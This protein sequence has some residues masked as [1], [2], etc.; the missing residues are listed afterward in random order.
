MI[1]IWKLVIYNFKCIQMNW[2]Y[3]THIQQLQTAFKKELDILRQ[4][5][6]LQSQVF[7]VKIILT[8][9]LP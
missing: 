7:R 8:R 1:T 4:V 5:V 9:D 3:L 2:R 6:N